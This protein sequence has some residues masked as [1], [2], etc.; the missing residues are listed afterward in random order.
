MVT[1]T[2]SNAQEKNIMGQTASYI[3]MNAAEN[4][5][6]KFAQF[7]TGAAHLVK[8]TE[9]GTEL[10]FALQ[11]PDDKLAIFDVFV[12][13]D[14]RNAHFA[15]VVAAALNEK[16]DS[17]VKDGWDDG[18]VSNINNSNVLSAKTPVDLYSATTATYI[19]LKATEG[20]SEELAVLLT[21]A[22]QIV[23]QTEPETLFWVALRLD[24]EN[25]AIYDIFADDSGRDAHFAG[26]VAGLLKEKASLLVEGGWDNGVV[27]NVNSYEI[28]AIK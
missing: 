16:A 19:K 12:D 6:A 13:D 10:W 27:A 4:Q 3:E 17:L 1:T 8:Q 21:A 23:S 9:P 7:L 18:V 14:A 24:N 28:L 11:G 26:T 15:G 22:G 20:Q 25:F 2:S 5:T